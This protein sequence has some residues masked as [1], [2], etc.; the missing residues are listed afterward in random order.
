MFKITWNN[1]KVVNLSKMEVEMPNDK[2]D[3]LIDVLEKQEIEVNLTL[4][5]W[6]DSQ[7]LTINSAISQ[8]TLALSA[9]LYAE[10]FAA[11]LYRNEL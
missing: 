5:L 2:I 11:Y 4:R 9:P 1:E 10:L 8:G 3:Q 6:L 7:S